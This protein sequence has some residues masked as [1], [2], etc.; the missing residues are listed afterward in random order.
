M[1]LL[2]KPK[3]FEKTLIRA[4]RTLDGRLA[5][6]ADGVVALRTTAPLGRRL[7]EARRH[8]TLALEP[9]QCRVERAGRSA[10]SG[11]ATN[12]VADRDAVRIVAEAQD[13]EQDELLELAEMAVAA[14]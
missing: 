3:P 14:H 11:A 5:G 12:L 7:A 1:F 10:A 6:R 9:L 4:Q 13:R 2:E 8:Q